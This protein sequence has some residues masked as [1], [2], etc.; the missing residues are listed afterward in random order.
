MPMH[1]LIRSKKLYA[2]AALI[3]IC[4]AVAVILFG[5]QSGAPQPSSTS[6][7]AQAAVAPLEELVAG[8]GRVEPV[9]EEVRVG[10]AISGKLAEVPVEEGQTVHKGQ[11]IAALENDDYRA[12]IA[13]AEAQLSERQ[14]ELQRVINGARDQERREAWAKVEEADAVMKTSQTEMQRSES[15]FKDGVIS[16]EETERSERDYKMA[17]ASYDAAMQH[18]QTVN[19]AARE[20]ER[21]K[22]E[23]DVQL[24]RSQIAEARA[25]LEKTIIRSPI[26]GVVLKKHKKAGESVSEA[27]DNPIATIGDTSALRVRVDVDE[28]DVGKIQVGQRAY[29]TANAYGEQKFWGRV[30]RIGQVL[31]RKNIR[32]DEPTERADTKILE[33]LL[34]LE[35]GASLPPGLRVDAF[36]VI[37]SR[38]A[39]SN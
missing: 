28:S 13:T 34:E 2:G 26:T 27:L 31:G 14:A 19:A 32:T 35:P 38:P 7:A 9:S 1:Q 21:A 4:G 6:Q 22:A 15:L 11:V 5:R 25:L 12:R 17:K 24:A 16:R 30:V 10:S 23:A 29:V 8:P 36:I 20:D 37:N 39:K 33:T 18:Y 3:V